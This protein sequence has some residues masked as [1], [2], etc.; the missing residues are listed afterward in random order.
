MSEFL[1]MHAHAL[2]G[3][4]HRNQDGNDVVTDSFTFVRNTTCPNQ[5]KFVAQKDLLGAAA[6]QV[7]GPEGILGSIQSALL[8]G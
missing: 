8:T 4:C 7:T 1:R 6:A 5:S 2:S 3:P